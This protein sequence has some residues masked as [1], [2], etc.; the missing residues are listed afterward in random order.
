M[1]CISSKV[2]TRSLSIQE[3]LNHSLQRRTNGVPVLEELFTSTNGND[4]HQFLTLVCTADKAANELRTGSFT[5]LSKTGPKPPPEPTNTEAA[6]ATNWELMAGLKEQGEEKQAVQ[7]AESLLL[8][9]P[10]EV[11]TS[12]IKTSKRSKS[13]HRIDGL[14]EGEYDWENKGMPRSRSFHTI[15]EFD[16][17]LEKIQKGLSSRAH[18]L[19][20]EDYCE[21]VTKLQ[22]QDAN[23]SFENSRQTDQS[24]LRD[25]D[26]TRQRT[27]TEV[28]RVSFTSE[29]ESKESHP[30]LNSGSLAE[31]M[32]SVEDAAE[33]GNVS[34]K[35]I[36]RKSVAKG[37]RSLEIPSTIELP[38]IGSLREW[39]HDGGQAFTPK[40]GSYN[41]ETCVSEKDGDDVD[42]IFSPEMVAA[43]E[44]CMQQLEV[45]EES[46]IKQ[47]EG[48]L[49]VDDS[50][51]EGS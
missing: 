10:K 36:K 4:H 15:E 46:I 30:S 24:V 14:K 44:E 32:D 19:G 13:F 48:S 35:G 5:L 43:F 40:F 11:E 41:L 2:L 29:P 27:V 37:L 39:L 38:T 28:Y 42:S 49:K 17:M 26:S 31:E 16:A 8:S 20:L 45:E 25:E 18:E 1:G 23:A 3:E 33:E 7:P 12:D 6:A 21:S 9:P 47:I 22:F 50:K 51:R 34:E